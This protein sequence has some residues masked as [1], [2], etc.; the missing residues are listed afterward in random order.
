MFVSV[1]V[2][3]RRFRSAHSY[4]F[5]SPYVCTRFPGGQVDGHSPQQQRRGSNNKG[6]GRYVAFSSIPPL[7]P[8]CFCCLRVP[9]ICRS[10]PQRRQTRSPATGLAV[11]ATQP[12]AL[13]VQ[14]RHHL[15]QYKC[16]N[17]AV[18]VHPACK[19]TQAEYHR[20]PRRWQTPFESRAKLGRWLT[21]QTLFETLLWELYVRQRVNERVCAA[22]VPSSSVC[23]T[24]GAAS[25][26]A[27][28]NFAVL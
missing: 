20:A 14:N 25:K 15:K 7:L 16:E 24:C 4:I 26:H 13:E 3:P 28:M 9:A 17:T 27:S 23:L 19:S 21:G 10:I 1:G 8:L 18:S 11:C 12:T 6:D 5:L 2:S 22:L